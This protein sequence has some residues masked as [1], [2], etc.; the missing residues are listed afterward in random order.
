MW[1]IRYPDSYPPEAGATTSWKFGP[2]D[3]STASSKYRGTREKRHS[4]L[5]IGMNG[6]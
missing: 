1:S 3:T 5:H 4:M 6:A 2:N